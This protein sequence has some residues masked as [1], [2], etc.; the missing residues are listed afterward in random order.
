[1]QLQV[2]KQRKQEFNLDES[3]FAHSARSVMVQMPGVEAA[4][5]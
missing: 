2:Q 3:S 1:M 5:I 4:R